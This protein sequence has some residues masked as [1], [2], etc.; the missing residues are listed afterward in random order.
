MSIAAQNWAWNQKID[1]PAAKLLLLALADQTDS[2]DG[3]VRYQQTTAEFFSEKCG[4]SLR[5]FWR[6]I[7]ELEQA[8]LLRRE[9]GLGRGNLTEFWLCLDGTGKG[10]NLAGFSDEKVCQIVQ[11]SVPD[12]VEKGTPNGTVSD[13]IHYT[14]YQSTKESTSARARAR[15]GG[16]PRAPAREEAKQWVCYRTKAWFALLMIAPPQLMAKAERMA[17]SPFGQGTGENRGT[18][19][20]YFQKGLY[21]RALASIGGMTYVKGVGL[22]PATGPPDDDAAT[23]DGTESEPG[24]E[25]DARQFAAGVRGVSGSVDDWGGDRVRGGE[26]VDGRSGDRLAS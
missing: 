4:F 1:S 3:S 22:F 7:G 18:N 16:A 13:P 15:D 17:L 6:C 23:D 9:G 8:G 20:W 10:A 19:G 12:T 14:N 2:R 5:T 26:P 24:N 11:E 25:D 21:D